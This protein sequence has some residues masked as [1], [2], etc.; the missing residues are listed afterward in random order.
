MTPEEFLALPEEK[1]YLEFIGGMAVQKPMVNSA[2]RRIVGE[3]CYLFG[4]YKRD[5]GGDFGPEG[6][7]QLGDLPNFRLLDVAY[8][9]A[10][11]P[12]G[13][14]ST[15]TLVVEVPS[16]GQ[17][18]GELREKCRAFLGAG[19][20]TCWIIDPG[21]RVAEVPEHAGAR[22]NGSADGLET[23]HLPGLSILLGDL[24]AVADGA[25]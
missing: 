3:L 6:R 21:T 5:H 19:V 22:V 1:P 12:S 15:P 7:V 20:Q 16:P 13:E 18:M 11:R 8:W 9:A 2:H 25:S 14:D 17:T 23:S 4:Q 10:G 24:F